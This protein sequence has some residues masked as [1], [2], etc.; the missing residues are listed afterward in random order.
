M[1]R[2]TAFAAVVLGL[3]LTAAPARA[4]SVDAAI[5]DARAIVRRAAQPFVRQAE[6]DACAREL[7]R[8]IVTGRAALQGLPGE[9]RAQ[10]ADALNVA[11]IHAAFARVTATRGLD[12]TSDLLPIADAKSLLDLEHLTEPQRAR[13]LRCLTVLHDLSRRPTDE[14]V[15]RSLRGLLE[16]DLDDCEADLRAMVNDP[17]LTAYLRGLASHHAALTRALRARVAWV[18]GF[19]IHRTWPLAHLSTIVDKAYVDARTPGAR[20]EAPGLDLRGLPKT[21]RTGAVLPCALRLDAPSAPEVARWDVETIDAAGARVGLKRVSPASASFELFGPSKPGAYVV[22]VS[23]LLADDRVLAR[24]FPLEVTG[25]EVPTVV[26]P[27]SGTVELPPSP[28]G[29]LGL[30]GSLR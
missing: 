13:V 26:L 15:D 10:A 30:A 16:R 25:P 11:T 6:A 2:L 1:V 4:Q 8:T 9:A 21:T 29:S 3:V 23:A 20:P 5:A 24:A 14:R 12:V 17:A 19:T 7:A 27:P 18:G 22:L 28:S